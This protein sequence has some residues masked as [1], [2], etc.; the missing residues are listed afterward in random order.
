MLVI[1]GKT[2]ELEPLPLILPGT[3]EYMFASE[4]IGLF[5]GAWDVAHNMGGEVAF[6]SRPGS[7]GLLEAVSLQEFE[8]YCNDGEMEVRQ[9]E[10]EEQWA[11]E[12]DIFIDSP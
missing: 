6:I 2:Q 9:A 11:L 8:E 12:D 5:P 3:L 7:G 4:E 1:D 10:L